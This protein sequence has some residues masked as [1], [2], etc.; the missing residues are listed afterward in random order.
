[1]SQ[2]FGNLFLASMS[3]Q[4][5]ARLMLPNGLWFLPLLN[6]NPARYYSRFQRYDSD[7]CTTARGSN[8]VNG[9]SRAYRRPKRCWEMG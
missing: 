8:D 6:A 5:K 1:M 4:V 3:A 2:P 7:L 9:S